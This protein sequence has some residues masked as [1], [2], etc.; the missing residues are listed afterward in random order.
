M[1]HATAKYYYLDFT[2]DSTNGCWP[3]N[4]AFDDTYESF[5][6]VKFPEEKELINIVSV[7]RGVIKTGKFLSPFIDIGRDGLCYNDEVKKIID[8]LNVGRLRTWKTKI[9]NSERKYLMYYYFATSPD[10]FS[11]I[12]L[13]KSEYEWLSEEHKLLLDVTKY[14]I[15]PSKLPDLDL[16]VIEPYYWVVS[17]KAYE[18][19]MLAK[20]KI[21]GINF[22]VL[23]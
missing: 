6:L 8:Q 20:P 10:L 5:E 12:D 1:N 11:V 18:L 14:V 7:S 2:A 22:R 13:S 19:F 16:F 17:W 23:D 15:I 4:D 9:I 3:V 21:R